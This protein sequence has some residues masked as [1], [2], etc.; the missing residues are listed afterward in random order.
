MVS[1]SSEGVGRIRLIICG[2]TLA[3]SHNPMEVM[4]RIDKFFPM[5]EES[6]GPPDI[7]RGAK[8]SKVRLSNG[9]EAWAISSSKYVKEGVKNVE[10]YLGKEYHGRSLARKTSTPM[11]ITYRPE[12]DI[13]PELGPEKASYY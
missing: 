4:R 8:L 1:R 6:M 7:Y 3:I 13:T 5:N 11:K 9:V 2:N 10:D 12:L